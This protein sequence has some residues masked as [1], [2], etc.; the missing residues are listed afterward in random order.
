MAAWAAGRTGLPFVDACMRALIATGWLNFRM[1]AMLMA[2]A[3]LF[4]DYEPGIHWS[5][6]QMQSGTTGI[7]TIRIYNPIKQG[8]DHDPQGCFIRR[9]LPELARMPAVNL[10][11]PW[12]MPASTQ[13]RVDPAQAAREAREAI[14]SRRRQQGFAELADAIQERHGSRRSG[15]AASAR[16]RRRQP[17]V[18]DPTAVQLQF[19]L[20]S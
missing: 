1:R 17:A 12:T 4:V 3:R 6:C 20:G 18:Q 11:E 13:R 7:N 14:W 8:H 16:R 2:V 15:L 10:H 9:W 5:Q 19:E